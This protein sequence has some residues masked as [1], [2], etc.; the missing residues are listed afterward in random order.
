MDIP[1]PINP[2][3]RPLS[4]T[5]SSQKTAIQLS[6]L[7]KSI[8]V[9]PKAFKEACAKAAREAYDLGETND[10]DAYREEMEDILLSLLDRSKKNPK[11]PR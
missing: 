2:K 6:H 3:H 4:G 11:K 7:G 9:D 5:S 10:E 8:A 1:S